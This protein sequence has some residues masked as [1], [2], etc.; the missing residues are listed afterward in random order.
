M[1]LNNGVTWPS[2]WVQ[3]SAVKFQQCNIAIGAGQSGHIFTK[4][5]VNICFRPR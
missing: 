2:D 3:L 1:Q 4:E 5:L